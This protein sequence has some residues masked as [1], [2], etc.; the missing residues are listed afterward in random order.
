MRRKSGYI[1]K[2]KEGLWEGQ[3]V[4]Q[5]QK[6]SIYGKSKEETKEALERIM[7]SIEDNIYIKP[8]KYTM[9]SWLK[10]WFKLYAK[11]TLRPS[12]F[13]NY[14]SNIDQH[15]IPYFGNM[16]LENVS[17]RKLQEFFNYKQSA[18]RCDKKPGGLSIK[19]LKNIKYLLHVAFD[20]A[21]YEHIIPQNPVEG[22]KLPVPEQPEQ[23]VMTSAEK[24]KLCEYAKQIDSMAAKGVII[25]LNCGLRKG[26]LLALQW[27][28]IDLISDQIAIKKSLSRLKKFSAEDSA[29]K[30]IRVDKYAPKK[31]KTGLYLGPVKTKKANR[32]IYLPPSVREALLDI[33]KIHERYQAQ[34]IY[35]NSFDL[36]F[37]T[38]TGRPYDPRTFET[39]YKEILRGAQIREMKLH[40]TR[41]TF[42]TEAMQ[43]TNDIVTV[44]DILGHAK[45]STTLDMYG[46]TFDD[47]RRALMA[48]FK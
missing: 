7:K 42:A 37:C 36:V 35:Q 41:H 5:K 29:Y 10:E 47:R 22:V 28:N 4:F 11:K 8:T 24:D 33:K 30:Y 40:S 15:L 45:P 13:L 31:N 23:S 2:R 39:E 25:L 16:L 18:G 6:C 46:H 3:Y 19:T 44:A 1:R 32:R 21:Y 43:I 26:E 9:T 34:N 14:E 20:Q 48:Q 38:E 12:T 17:T 27:Q